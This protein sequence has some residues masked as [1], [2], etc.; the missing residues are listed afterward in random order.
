SAGT[1]RLA[2]EAAVRAPVL[3]R[4][5]EGALWNVS[6][7]GE[8]TRIDPSTGRI[9]AFRNSGVAIPCGLAV[10]AGSVWVTDCTSPTLVRIDPRQAVVI[11][12]ITLPKT[13]SAADTGEVV[14][15]AGSLWVAQ[16]F[17]NPSW[18]DR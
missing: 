1:G 13:A 8:L 6:F 5:G 7:D 4:F 11:D 18:I 17:A 9:E 16:G 2:G 12:R 10:A 3:S 14:Y 15:G